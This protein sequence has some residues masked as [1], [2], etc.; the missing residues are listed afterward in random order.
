MKWCGDDAGNFSGLL[1]IRG[2]DLA[3]FRRKGAIW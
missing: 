1:S 3:H 2:I